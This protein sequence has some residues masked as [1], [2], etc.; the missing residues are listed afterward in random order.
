MVT[1]W[2]NFLGCSVFWCRSGTTKLCKNVQNGVV[3]VGDTVSW[4]QKLTILKTEIV[5]SNFIWNWMVI[6]K[7]IEKLVFGA[8]C[9]CQ[10]RV[11]TTLHTQIFWV[12]F[13]LACFTQL[14][15]LCWVVPD[16]FSTQGH[17]VVCVLERLSEVSW[18]CWS[19]WKQWHLVLWSL[20]GVAPEATTL[21]SWMD[22]I[23]NEKKQ[24]F[25]MRVKTSHSLLQLL[26]LL[27]LL[28]SWEKHLPQHLKILSLASQW[29]KSECKIWNVPPTQEQWGFKKKKKTLNI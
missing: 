1:R 13:F 7:S 29:R 23:S 25:K 19:L 18:A 22:T 8:D 3:M 6:F 17:M 9:G 24:L 5:K 11:P 27:L 12:I 28:F 26:L 14:I 16:C 20:P 10:P 4:L 15:F 21:W 2:G